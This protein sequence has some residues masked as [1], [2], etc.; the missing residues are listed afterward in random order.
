MKVLTT[1]AA[2]SGAKT[3]AAAVSSMP[4]NIVN[5]STGL[6]SG[7]GEEDSLGPLQMQV[8]HLAYHRLAF[9]WVLRS[10]SLDIDIKASSKLFR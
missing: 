5:M 7:E 3:A 2:A 10:T 9:H 4:T 1:K 6:F 8:P